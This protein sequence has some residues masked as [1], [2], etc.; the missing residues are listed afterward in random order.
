MNKDQK[1]R[2][3]CVPTIDFP[4]NLQS[5]IC[6]A[7]ECSVCGFH[8]IFVV[9][10]LVEGRKFYEFVMLGEQKPLKLH[11]VI[12][13]SFLEFGKKYGHCYSIP[14]LPDFSKGSSLTP[15]REREVLYESLADGDIDLDMFNRM[16]S[17]IKYEL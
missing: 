10:E 13:P 4:I 2:K 14:P 9:G 17:K 16:I 12:D 11:I 1:C 8:T 5:D 15:E 7:V 6:Y 3:G